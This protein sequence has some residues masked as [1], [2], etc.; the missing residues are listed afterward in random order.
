M[1]YE[2]GKAYRRSRLVY[3]VLLNK[4]FMIFQKTLTIYLQYFASPRQTLYTFEVFA[5]AIKCVRGSV[6]NESSQLKL[7]M[8]NEIVSYRGQRE[9][10]INTNLID[11]VQHTCDEARASSSG[12]TCTRAHSFW[13]SWLI[14]HKNRQC[15]P[16]SRSKF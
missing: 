13:E 9:K 5:F 8:L 12:F 4:F 11:Y 3:Y 16:T 14:R 6:T 2:S 1:N 7:Y 15:Q 10:Y